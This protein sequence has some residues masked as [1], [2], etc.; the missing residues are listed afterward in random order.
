MHIYVIHMHIDIALKITIDLRESGM[1]TYV[2]HMHIDTV[3]KTAKDFKSI[4]MFT[5]V[6]NAIDLRV[7]SCIHM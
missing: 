5:Y 6:K 3:V 7:L 1:Y 4:V 2:I